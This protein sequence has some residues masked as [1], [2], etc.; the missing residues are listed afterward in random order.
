MKEVSVGEAWGTKYPEQVVMATCEGRDG[1]R[2]IIPLGWM[3]PT[4]GS[5]PML[6]ISVGHTRFSHELISESGEFVLVFPNE[7]Q[8]E[9]MLFCGTKS[10]RDVDKFAE[11]GFEPLTAKQVKAPLIADSVACFEC[12]VVGALETGD[13]TIFAGEIVAAHVGET[14]KGRLYNFSGKFCGAREA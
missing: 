14:G 13:H 2:S 5:P 9:D 7:D 6:A 12:K 8:G 4:S 11:T 3:M 1:R 10:G